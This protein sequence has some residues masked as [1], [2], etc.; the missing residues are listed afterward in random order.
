MIKKR[1]IALVVIFTIITFGIYGIYW[2]VKTKRELVSKG[3]II[4]TSWLLIVPIANIYYYYK[5]CMGAGNVF[6]NEDE[7]M[8]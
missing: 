8:K 5:Y 6:K 4:P 1:N 3:A 7:S 2:M